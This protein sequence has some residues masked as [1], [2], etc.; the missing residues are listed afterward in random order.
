MTQCQAITTMLLYYTTGQMSKQI[1]TLL[2]GLNGGII[3]A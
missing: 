3:A 2:R 1:P